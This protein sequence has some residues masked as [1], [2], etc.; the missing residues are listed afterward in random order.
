M[1]LE[2]RRISNVLKLKKE[3]SSKV[4]GRKFPLQQQ[5]GT[6]S[7]LMKLA[8]VAEPIS[9]VFEKSWW[10]GKILAD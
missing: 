10:S 6:K 9:I 3:S 8:G 1:S 7:V 2:G 5:Q 4:L